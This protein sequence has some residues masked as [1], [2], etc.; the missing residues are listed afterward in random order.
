L[1]RLRRRIDR[2]VA[3]VDARVAGIAFFAGCLVISIFGRPGKQP[4]GKVDHSNRLGG[5]IRFG[6]MGLG[7]ILFLAATALL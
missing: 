4:L 3:V 5:P 2:V 7:W 1:A 6:G